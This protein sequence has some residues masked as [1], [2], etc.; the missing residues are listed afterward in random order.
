[1]IFKHHFSKSFDYVI[2]Y[3][4]YKLKTMFDD[5]LV[6]QSFYKNGYGVSLTL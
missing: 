5:L 3:Y 1:M 6:K 4:V 2:L